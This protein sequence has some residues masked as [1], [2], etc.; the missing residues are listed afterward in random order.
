MEAIAS[1]TSYF[2]PAPSKRPKQTK[3]PLHP[4]PN[5]TAAHKHHHPTPLL[6]TL[7]QGVN[8]PLCYKEKHIRLKFA[9]Y[10]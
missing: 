8:F 5:T 9:R 3:M 2:V 7:V 6:M 10:K 1:H 4:T